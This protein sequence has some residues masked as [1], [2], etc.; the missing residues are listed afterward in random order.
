MHTMQSLAPD[1]AV[2]VNHV[3]AHAGQ[4]PA[5]APE[6]S[7]PALMSGSAAT[8]GPCDD[9]VIDAAAPAMTGGKGV[10]RRLEMDALAPPPPQGTPLPRADTPMQQQQQLHDNNTNS[11]A[12][13][14]GPRTAQ[15]MA[16]IEMLYNRIGN[17]PHA[18]PAPIQLHGALP[19]PL[20]RPDQPA[21]TAAATA[22]A[23]HT[24][25]GSGASAAAQAAMPAAASM[26]AA[27]SSPF[28]LAAYRPPTGTGLAPPT[29][30]QPQ[31]QLPKVANIWPVIPMG[32]A[33]A[34]PAMAGTGSQ[35]Q[36]PPQ[37]TL[38]PGATIGG[39]LPV[40][41]LNL[42]PPQ[43]LTG[44]LPQGTMQP[45]PAPPRIPPAPLRLTGSNGATTAQLPVVPLIVSPRS[46]D[47]GSSL[48]KRTWPEEGLMSSCL[49]GLTLADNSPAVAKYARV[50]YETHGPT[51][52][53]LMD[54]GS[55]GA[56]MHGKCTIIL[57]ALELAANP[58]AGSYVNA[59]CEQ[60][61]PAEA[62]AST[63]T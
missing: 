53:A 41:P 28:A 25:A 18:N 46:T 17:N 57:H 45:A 29:Q 44:P 3:G 31:P 43:Q 6:A 26:P 34:G 30:P 47:G 35:Q 8:D 5:G 21:P 60:G 32:P 39:L 2:Y 16:Q 48:G 1:I 61:R 7:E 58:C 55:T 42:G 59:A 49:D 11:P 56:R 19:A 23:G 37:S 50:A 13:V 15:A 62:E 22:A 27:K 4:E 14:E 24:L 33:A 40:G 51:S 10:Q 63:A 12:L 36:A 54:A 9:P 52:G 38:Q 20:F